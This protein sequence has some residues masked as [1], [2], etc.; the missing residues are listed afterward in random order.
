[1]PHAVRKAEAEFNAQTPRCLSWDISQVEEWITSIGF[2]M[3][4]VGNTQKSTT[5]LLIVL[6]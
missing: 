3:Y 1:M 6:F 4:T 2:P 5:Y